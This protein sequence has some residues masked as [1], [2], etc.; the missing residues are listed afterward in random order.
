M[1]KQVPA[2]QPL[3]TPGNLLR[4]N[5]IKVNRQRPLSPWINESQFKAMSF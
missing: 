3:I 4:H 2:I 5:A 1:R